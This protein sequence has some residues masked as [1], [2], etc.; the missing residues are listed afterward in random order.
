MRKTK[1]K[2]SGALR[3]GKPDVTYVKTVMRMRKKD[4]RET[5]IRIGLDR[6]VEFKSEKLEQIKKQFPYTVAYKKQWSF[7]TVDDQL[8]FL[9]RAAERLAQ[10]EKIIYEGED[11]WTRV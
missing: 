1:L 4:L 10:L 2:Q 7:A 5:L 8:E 3:S 9:W 6:S 11:K